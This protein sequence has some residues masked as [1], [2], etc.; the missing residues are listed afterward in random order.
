MWVCHTAALGKK[1]S[2][3][4]FVC[5][6]W[7]VIGETTYY[8]NKLVQCCVVNP[9]KLPLCFLTPELQNLIFTPMKHWQ[10]LFWGCSGWYMK[11]Q[12][13]LTI[14]LSMFLIIYWKRHIWSFIWVALAIVCPRGTLSD[15]AGVTSQM[16]REKAEK[17]D[18]MRS[19]EV[20]FISPEPVPQAEGSQSMFFV[21]RVLFYAET[22]CRGSGNFIF[23]FSHF[24][25]LGCSVSF[26]SKPLFAWEAVW[27]NHRCL[28][29]CFKGIL[30]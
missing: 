28:C 26:F 1:A 25:V 24:S 7:T 11:N 13:H 4:H 17:Q 20:C 14:L 6:N 27:Y 22:M 18:M 8:L 30:P 2:V 29:G 12:K 3:I 16:C 10:S 9:L 23:G 19:L 21:E 5:F 15:A